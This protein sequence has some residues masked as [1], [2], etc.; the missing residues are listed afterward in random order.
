MTVGEFFGGNV[1]KWHIVFSFWLLSYRNYRKKQQQ[2][3]RGRGSS[4]RRG[5]VA[6]ELDDSAGS[7]LPPGLKAM[8]NENVLL[9]LPGN[10][11]VSNQMGQPRLPHGINIAIK[12]CALAR[13][14]GGPSQNS[15]WFWDQFMTQFSISLLR[16]YHCCD[17]GSIR[18]IPVAFWQIP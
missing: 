17:L 14:K 7:D 5:G 18:S 13:S 2:R 10:Y 1:K 8:R 9:T 15:L 12:R 4:M 16:W 11:K 6:S 3:V